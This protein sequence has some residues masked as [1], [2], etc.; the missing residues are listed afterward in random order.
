L[1][2]QY[3][4]SIRPGQTVDIVLKKDQRTGLLTRGV[5]K[6]LLTKSPQHIHGIK[7]RL[8][9]GQVGRVKEIIEM[10]TETDKQKHIIA[11]VR[12]NRELREKTYRERAMNLFPHVCGKCAREFSGKKLKELTVHHRDHDH[13]NNPPDGS[14]WELLCI[15]C[16]DNEHSR[17][18]DAQWYT[19]DAP[20]GDKAPSSS[21]KPFAGLA[22]LMNKKA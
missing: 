19:A 8:A 16:H 14:N 1:E 10:P 22:D 21:E 6:D 3:R 17:H 20:G 15:Y 4:K 11:E 18:V 9:D 7:V 5:V 13:D 12:H 2:N